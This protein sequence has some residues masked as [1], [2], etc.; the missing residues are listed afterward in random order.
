VNRERAVRTSAVLATLTV[1]AVGLAGCSANQEPPARHPAT[2]PTETRTHPDPVTTVVRDYRTYRAGQTGVLNS[3]S[4][5]AS[6]RLTVSRPSRSTTRLSSYGDPPRYGYYVTFRL[7][8]TNTGRVPIL[9]RR[10][11]FWVRTSGAA[12]TTT[13]AGNAPYSGSARQLDTT[14]LAPGQQVTN[15]LTFDLAQPSGRLFY[16]PAGR[17]QLAWSF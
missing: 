17:R 16:G 4:Q 14:Q 2:S 8:I 7:A 3:P 11:D 1:L 10:L 13:D 9:L 5:H 15:D 12:K 6:L